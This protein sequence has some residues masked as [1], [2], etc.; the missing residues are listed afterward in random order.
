[1]AGIRFCGHVAAAS[2][3]GL[4]KDVKRV[5]I[6][7]PSHHVYL[8]SIALSQATE[9]ETPFGKLPVDRSIVTELADT[10]GVNNFP[11]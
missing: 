3:A 6:L 4:R 8:D 10:V 1:M 9:L 7:G 5:F 2:F 11:C